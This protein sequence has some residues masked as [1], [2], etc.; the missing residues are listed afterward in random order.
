MS[1][2]AKGGG[3]KGAN[4]KG[5]AGRAGSDEAG[6]GGPPPVGN[7]LAGIGFI[8]DVVGDAEDGA[9]VK[10]V[11]PCEGTVI[12]VGAISIVKGAR[13]LDN[14]KKFFDWALGAKAQA[15]IVKATRAY[16]RTRRSRAR[17]SRRNSARSSSSTTTMPSTTS[18][19]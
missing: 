6:A 3:A 12:E 8:G 17:R 5:R 7:A 4:A 13:N 1:G 2:V 19:R 11:A 9:A 16:P 18:R 14:A 10:A 15:L